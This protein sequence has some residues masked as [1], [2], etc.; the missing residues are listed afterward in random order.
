MTTRAKVAGSSARN[1]NAQ[2]PAGTYK[3]NPALWPLLKP[4]ASI[5]ADP[6]NRNKHSERSIV[7]I[8]ASY[9]KFGQQK[10]IVTR[11]D[12]TLVAGE[13]QWVAAR[14]RLN[15]TH[16]A[17]LTYDGPLEE[18]EQYALVDNRSQ[19]QSVWDFEGLGNSLKAMQDQG[20]DLAE[21]GWQPHEAMTL[22]QAEWT[23]AAIKSLNEG[24]EKVHTLTFNDKQWRTVERVALRVTRDEGE[25][26]DE[27]EAV[28]KALRDWL[29]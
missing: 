28:V 26:A 27:A 16:I 29:K 22:I 24:H 19:E 8:A 14:D 13:G 5:K 6:E 9:R 3:V 15:W 4:I 7:D 1:G 2:A 25:E 10:P 23:P 21:L 18:A 20:I 17:A 11:S 12:G